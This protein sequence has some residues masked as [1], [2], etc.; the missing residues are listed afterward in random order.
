MRQH[1]EKYD[2]MGEGS[3]DI[4]NRHRSR[5]AEHY[6]VLLRAKCEGIPFD[7]QDMTNDFAR[8]LIPDHELKFSENEYPRQIYSENDPFGVN[9]LSEA[10]T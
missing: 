3:K 6:R 8:E 9:D 2:L 10:V 1:L 5:A 4:V 7:V